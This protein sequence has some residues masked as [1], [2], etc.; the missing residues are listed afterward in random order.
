MNNRLVQCRAREV[1]GGDGRTLRFTV[2][3]EEVARDG[4]ILRVAGWDT[5]AFERNPVVLWSH[6]P[7]LPPIGKAV[8]IRK[9]GGSSPVLQADIEFAGLE[10]M[11]D[12]AETVFN[13]YR[14]GYLSAV[15]VGYDIRE[16]RQLTAARRKSLGLPPGGRESIKQEL[17]EISAV[18]VPADTGALIQLAASSAENREA[19]LAVRSALSLPPAGWLSRLEDR[20]DAWGSGR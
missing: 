8:A 13:L 2:S 9:T 10:Q 15:S 1:P 16:V 14:D 7:R 6:D 19:V 3:T 4:D 20:L 11:H 17:Y 18:S 12:L 5:S